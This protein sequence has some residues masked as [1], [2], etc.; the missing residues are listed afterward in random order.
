M[1]Q[2]NVY[3]FT[4]RSKNFMLMQDGQH[5]QYESEMRCNSKLEQAD[6]AKLEAELKKK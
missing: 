2:L 5:D 1:P 3:D 6:L 4:K